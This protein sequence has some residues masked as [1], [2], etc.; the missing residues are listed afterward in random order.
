MSASIRIAPVI[1][2][3]WSAPLVAGVAPEPSPATARTWTDDSRIGQALNEGAIRSSTLRRLL[4]AIEALPIRVQLRGRRCWISRAEACTRLAGRAGNIRYVVI[5]VPPQR[6]SRELPP[7]I[8]HELR[9]AIEIGCDAS[10]VDARSMEA[11]FSRIGMRTGKRRYETREAVA[12]ENAI[13]MELE[14]SDLPV[15]TGPAARGS[16]VATAGTRA[17]ALDQRCLIR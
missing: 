12:I 13:R 8:G 6:A 9:H 15:T 10:V 4:E 1:L 17:P 5:H 2:L 16:T 3:L 11:L 14:H 7:L